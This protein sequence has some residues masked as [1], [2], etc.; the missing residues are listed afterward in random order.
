MELLSPLILVGVG[1]VLALA[2]RRFVW[3]LIAAAGFLAAFWLTSLLFPEGGLVVLLV[4]LAAGLIGSFLLRG[5]VAL[6]LAI[7]GFVF[8]GTAAVA[9]GSSFGI[10][11]W[12]LGWIVIFLAGGVLGILLARFVADLGLIIITALGGASMVMMGLPELGLSL[13]ASSQDLVGPVIA[14]AGFVVQYSTRGR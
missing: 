10:E 14:V 1:L 3:L 9:L 13:A 11:V 7:A 4:S 8:V 6:A 5:L 2:G 12:S